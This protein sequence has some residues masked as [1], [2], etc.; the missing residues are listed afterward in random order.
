MATPLMIC[1]DG[2][3]CGHCGGYGLVGTMVL[4][5]AAPGFSVL[6]YEPPEGTGSIAFPELPSNTGAC[7]AK[8]APY[9]TPL[10]ESV[11][12]RA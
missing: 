4:V 11:L 3:A 9:V 7:F 2:C 12:D 10:F 1:G 8:S 5:C 6:G